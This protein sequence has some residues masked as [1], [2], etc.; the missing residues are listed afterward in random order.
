M[1]FAQTAAVFTVWQ[2][3][4]EICVPPGHPESQ[5]RPDNQ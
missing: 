5:S 2:P 3:C 1:F 4:M